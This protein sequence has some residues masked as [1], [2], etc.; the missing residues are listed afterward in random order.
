MRHS[1]QTQDLGTKVEM[2]GLIYHGT[3]LLLIM[4]H[5]LQ[6]PMLQNR[7]LHMSCNKVS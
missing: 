5:E 6:G 1:M 2:R 3:I 4:S 7:G